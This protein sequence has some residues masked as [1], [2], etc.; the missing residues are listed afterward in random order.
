MAIHRLRRERGFS[1]VELLLI[2]ALI[3]IMALFAVP[4]VQRFTLRAKMR[5]SAEALAA[6]IQR[7][8]LYA[9]QNNK[10]VVGEIVE[11]GRALL[12]WADV[13]GPLEGDPPD[14][15]YNPL[16]GKTRLATDHVITRVPLDT[17]VFFGSPAGTATDGFTTLG[18][19]TA[20][21]LFP[22]GSAQDPG[23]FNL[24]F[25]VNGGTTSDNYLQVFVGPAATAHT[26]VRK[27]DREASA[28]RAHREGGQTWTWYSP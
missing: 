14:L 6:H 17:N 27:W 7:A 4:A 26:V 25:R 8:R 13:N 19:R 16:E 9:I 24:G 11:D 21:L 3:S 28:W 10:N 1:L 2:L 22:S 15:V 20:L 23:S 18:T 12:L 5:A